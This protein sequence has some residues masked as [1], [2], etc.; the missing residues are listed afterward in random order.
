MNSQRG[1]QKT[2]LSFSADDFA[3]ALD[4]YSYD[5]RRGQVVRGTVYAHEGD[6]AF[7]DIGAK[8]PAFL[9]MREIFLQPS[10]NLSEALPLGEE[11]EFLIIRDEDGQGQVTLSLQQLEEK[12]AWD[13]IADMEDDNQSVHA[14]VTGVNKGGVT[15]NVQGLRGFIPRSHLM[16][17]KNLEG[18]VGQ[19]LIANFLEIDP[20]RKKLVLSQRQLAKSTRIGQLEVGQLVQGE[21]VAI[22][23][24]GVFVDLEGV[25]ALLPIKQVSKNYVESL[26]ALFHIGQ[27]IK[28]IVLS[29]DEAKGRISLS[30]RVLENYP[31]EM[32]QDSNEVIASAE[33]RRDRIGK[34][35]S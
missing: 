12:K 30:T 26:G 15:V 1:S 11:L 10:E 18:L 2:K 29:L 28:A 14:L 6:G 24:F 17:R 34:N 35:L 33:A 22:K 23:P 20:E 13:R 31:G 3:K 27:P 9:P 4:E 8:S 16:E 32:I 19:N 7:I 25:T 5:F 21:V